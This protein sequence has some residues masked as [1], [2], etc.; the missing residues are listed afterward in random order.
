MTEAS[1]VTHLQPL[2]IDAPSKPGS[3]GQVVPNTEVKIVDLTT[4]Q[5][6]GPRGT[7]E[8]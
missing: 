1:P 7:G 6:L 3:I 8:S 5:A 4:G 2:T